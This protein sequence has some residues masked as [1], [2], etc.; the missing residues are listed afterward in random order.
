MFFI[1]P[2]SQEDVKE[3]FVDDDLSDYFNKGDIEEIDEILHD[4]ILIYERIIFHRR[5]EILT[6]TSICD[7]FDALQAHLKCY[8]D[9]YLKD[10]V[11]MKK[12]KAKFKHA[13]YMATLKNKITLDDL[14]SETYEAFPIMSGKHPS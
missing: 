2:Q 6:D 5:R 10:E 14:L 1:R 4:F 7:K 11:F 8:I 9:Q 3:F 13:V 12:F